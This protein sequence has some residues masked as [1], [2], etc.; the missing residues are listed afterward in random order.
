MLS[1][2]REGSP[3][4]VHE[5]EALVV[6]VLQQVILAALEGPFSQQQDVQ[7]L[8]ELLLQQKSPW[9]WADTNTQIVP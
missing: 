9:P 5:E 8:P 1:R 2:Q 3:N 6:S 4:D 7:S